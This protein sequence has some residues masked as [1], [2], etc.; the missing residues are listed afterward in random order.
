MMS[1]VHPLRGEVWLVRFDPT[2]GAEKSKLRPAIVISE[3][4]I[5]KLP[6]R[7]VVPITDWKP[8]YNGFPWMVKLEPVTK[9]GLS[10]LS[11]ADGFQVKS[12]SVKRFDSRLGSITDSQ[13]DNVAAAI[14]ICVGSPV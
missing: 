10:K 5:G 1:E 6:L 14:A 7:I 11:G 9:N 8:Q 4:S 13:A 12:V 3:N 2:V